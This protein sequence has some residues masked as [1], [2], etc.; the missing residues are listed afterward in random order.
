MMTFYVFGRFSGGYTQYP[1]DILY[2]VFQKIITEAKADT[3]VAIH[4]DG[5]LM[6]YCYLRKFGEN[7]CIGFC[8]LISGTYVEQV[9]STFDIFEKQIEQIAYRGNILHLDSY[10]NLTSD[11]YQL[12]EQT[13][14]INFITDEITRQFS[15][16]TSKRP[17]LPPSDY[18]VA[19]Q[20]VATFSLEDESDDVLYSSYTFG[21]TYILK[22][23][24]YNTEKMNA[25]RSTL[26]RLNKDKDELS[27]KCKRLV[28]ALAAERNKRR[29]LVWV[30]VLSIVVIIMGTILYNK[31]LFP[32][33][34]THYETGEFVYYGPLKDG[35]PNGVGVAIYPTDDKDGRK[36]YIGNFENG[37]RQDSAAVLF[38]QDG[39]YYY[40]SMSGDNWQKGMLYMNSDNSHFIGRFQDNKPYT[41]KWYDHR[42]SYRLIKGRK[43]Y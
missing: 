35:K 17:P 1:N 26:K 2:E 11:L 18:S 23:D 10:G 27:D 5:N 37:E 13:E 40:G 6:Y 20:S 14:E 16:L 19:S 8:V 32:S 34:V 41:G 7:E 36:Y 33:E 39:D 21:Y 12:Y 22:E 24:D 3:Q 31:V 29:N 25:Y 42:L 4:R 9:L 30:G 38:Y 43:E 28:Q 15:N